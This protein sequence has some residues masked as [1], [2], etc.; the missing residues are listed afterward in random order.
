MPTAD[1]SDEQIAAIVDP[2]ERAIRIRALAKERN[3]LTPTQAA[4]Y[5]GAIAELRGDNERKHGWI[6]RRLGISRGRI[7]QLLNP[8]TQGATR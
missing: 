4:L 5:R 6:A 8:K 3:T 1:L 7:T 2:G